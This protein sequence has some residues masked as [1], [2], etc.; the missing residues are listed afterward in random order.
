MSQPQALRCV[1]G[2]AGFALV[3]VMIAM[4]VTA[5]AV[6]GLGVVMVRMAR[7]ATASSGS[8]YRS[9][10]T[11]AEVSRL[12][13]LPFDSLAT[14]APGC[15]TVNEPPQPYQRCTVINNI[16]SR[17]HEL[18]IVVTPSGNVLL[19]PDTVRLRRTRSNGNGSGGGFP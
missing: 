15:V 12:S 17:V 10:A 3:E 8:V 9:A 1:R 5:V 19:K 4:V 6:L 16:S 11:G 2:Q 18:I 13:A 14:L 7:T